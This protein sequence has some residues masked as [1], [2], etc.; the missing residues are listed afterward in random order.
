MST[1]PTSPSAGRLTVGTSEIVIGC[2]LERFGGGE[3]LFQVGQDVVDALDADRE[4][5]QARA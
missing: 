5:H 4:A 2:R 3:A 1:T